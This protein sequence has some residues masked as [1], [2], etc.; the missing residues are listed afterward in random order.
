[1][2]VGVFWGE[3]G[4]ISDRVGDGGGTDMER[5]AQRLPSLYGV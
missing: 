4:T 1:M 5:S 3:T 2:W